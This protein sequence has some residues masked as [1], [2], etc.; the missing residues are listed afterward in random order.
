MLRYYQRF[1]RKVKD[2]MFAHDIS[3]LL[4]KAATAGT[5]GGFVANRLIW[6][7][8]TFESLARMTF[9]ATGFFPGL[10]SETF[11]Y[12]RLFIALRGRGLGAI[13]LNSRPFYN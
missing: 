6:C 3:G 12:W 7:R 13:I 1:F 10:F 11:G 9:L 8:D 2:L 4:L 5:L